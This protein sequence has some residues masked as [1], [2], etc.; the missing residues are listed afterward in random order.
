MAK[1]TLLGPWVKTEPVPE[2]GLGDPGEEQAHGG[3]D[4]VSKFEAKVTPFNSCINHLT[5]RCS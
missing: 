4:E 1:V 5:D 2:R 3:T